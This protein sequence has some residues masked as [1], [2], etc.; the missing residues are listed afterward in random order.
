MAQAVLLERVTPGLENLTHADATVFARR[1]GEVYEGNL[2]WYLGLLRKALTP[3]PPRV[4]P[5]FLLVTTSPMRAAENSVKNAII[6]ELNTR[7][8]RVMR[9]LG[10][11]VLD[12][13]HM[14]RSD[15]AQSM[16]TDRVHAVAPYYTAVVDLIARRMPR[17]PLLKP[18]GLI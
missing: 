15:S 4:A 11:D 3:Q 2:R 17:S 9:M 18:P 12:I 13:S 8:T 7:A 5:Q 16:Y 6:D 10:H 1:W 14:L